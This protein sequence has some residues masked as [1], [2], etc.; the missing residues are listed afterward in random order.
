MPR[1]ARTVFAGIP[2]HVT[3]RG[4]RRAPVFHSD[5]DRMAYLGWLGEYGARH[6]MEVL[7]YCLMPNHVHLVV[8]PS[9]DDSLHRALKPLHTRHAQRVNRLRGSTG[10][11]WQGRFFS[12]ALDGPYLLAAVRYVESNPVRAGLVASAERFAW[13]SA[14]ARCGL[15]E[16]RIVAW[17][18]PWCDSL[19]EVANWQAFLAGEDPAAVALLRRQA[20]MCLPCGGEPFIEKLEKISG[21]CL[22]PGLPG[23]PRRADVQNRG[24]S[25]ILA[26]R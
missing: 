15:R 13:S 18:S 8:V 23:R 20:A 17:R 19:R 11:L 3:Q 21:R 4:N 6:G 12:S 5:A 25:P 16:D 22:R 26:E 14:A 9:G 1:I 7:A 24:A 2:H 10:H